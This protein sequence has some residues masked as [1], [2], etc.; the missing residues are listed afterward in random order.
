MFIIKDI[1]EKEEKRITAKYFD[2]LGLLSSITEE[3]NK[4]N[5]L[6]SPMSP[7]DE[8]LLQSPHDSIGSSNDIDDSREKNEVVVSKFNLSKYIENEIEKLLKVY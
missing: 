2:R 8:L 5:D 1:Q 4:K 3:E 7:G 6:N